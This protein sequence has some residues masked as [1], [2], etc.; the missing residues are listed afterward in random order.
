MQP[1]H[2][3]RFL[4]NDAAAADPACQ[5]AMAS[6]LKQLERERQQREWFAK[7]NATRPT[8]TYGTWHISDRD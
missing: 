5:Q 8:G 2:N 6:Y 1:A 7:W 3:G 4:I